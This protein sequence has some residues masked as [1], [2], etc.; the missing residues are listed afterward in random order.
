MRTR[1][2]RARSYAFLRKGNLRVLGT[3]IAILAGLVLTGGNQAQAA[4]FC[5]NPSGSDGCYTTIGDAVAAA[6]P[7]DTIQV[8]Q[9]T[10]KEDVVI[11]KPL[12][13][14]GHNAADTII[15]A[16][17]LANGI[18]VDGLDNS[19]LANVTVSGFTVE[20][21][22]FEG[23]LITNASSVAIQGN[24]VTGNDRSLNFAAGKC[25]GLPAFETAEGED[26]GEGI[27]L[28]G[29]ANSF[30]SSN[31]IDGNSGGVLVSD[32]TGPTHDNMIANN[33]V[34]KNLLDCGITIPSHPPAP[35]SG[36]TAPFG[37]YSNTIT[38]NEVLYNGVEGV[39]AGI[40]LFGFLPGAR[41]SDN[42]IS[43]NI[44]I[45]NGLPGVTMHAHS[46]GE[47][48]NNNTITGNYISGNGADSA[49]AKTPG[50]SGI[51][52]YINVHG[53]SGPSGIV[54][55]KNVIKNET[56]DI[57]LHMPESVDVHRNNLNG[58]GQGVVNLGTSA[59]D[60]SNNWWGC[61]MGPGA[62]GCSQVTGSNVTVAPWLSS[63]AVPNGSPDAQH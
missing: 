8:A 45:G 26:C 28:S 2:T 50:P 25:P 31:L 16:T 27:H 47:N 29:V 21:A 6:S 36:G 10:Y 32:E 1:E 48:M 13:L 37:V 49:D 15:D 34:K 51:N 58:H 33:V 42:L 24:R 46:P 23:I 43:K 12:S 63:P 30:L 5:V 11:G 53:A 9:G 61:A 54:V 18:Y 7:G 44:I 3:A 52:L 4:S 55:E 14:I 40:G 39:G 35:G 60:A 19:G 38:G 41:V 62:F 17:G 57:V 20:N 56:D 22:N 59:V